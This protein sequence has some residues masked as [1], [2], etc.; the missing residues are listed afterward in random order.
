MLKSTTEVMLA[1]RTIK[2]LWWQTQL[3]TIE[4]SALLFYTCFS[5]NDKKIFNTFY[6]LTKLSKAIVSMISKTTRIHTLQTLL[7]RYLTEWQTK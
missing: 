1:E 5:C 4:F 2:I 3:E 6:F 7:K